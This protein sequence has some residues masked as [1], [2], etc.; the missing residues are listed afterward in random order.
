MKT[1]LAIALGG[2]ILVAAPGGRPFTVDDEMA[3]RSLVDVAI[4]PDGS[5]VAYVVSTPALA[6]DEHDAALFVVDV[7]EREAF[8][9]A[10]VATPVRL[11]EKLHIFNTPVPRPQLR[12]SPDSKTIALAATASN[13]PQVFAVDGRPGPSGPG[14][15]RQ[16]TNAPEG[17]FGF[18]WSPDGKSLAYLTRD[19]MSADEE[20][21][22]QDKSFVIR[23]DAPD[24]PARLTVQSL[25]AG[26]RP[27]TLT[28]P[29][30]YIDGFSW[31]PGGRELAYSAAPRS[32]FSAP[33]ED[34]LYRVS[35]DGGPPRTIVDRPGMNSFPKFSPDG[36]LLA[37]I[38]TTGHTDIMASRSLTVVAS[39]GGTPRA[40]VLDDAWANEYVWAPDSKSIYF[41]ANDGTFGRGAH[42]FEQ[43]VVRISVADG[44]AESVTAGAPGNVVA[45]DL[46][47]SRDGR[48][49]A[50]KGIEGRTMGDVYVLDT[51]NRAAK[52]LTDINPELRDI[53]LGDLK[54]VSWKS[55]DGMEIWGLLL[56]PPRWTPGQ[57][58]PLITYIHGGP[59]GGVT[60]G[61]FPQ[62][63]HSISQVDPYPTEALAS[64]G[65]AVLFPM[66]RGGAGYGEAG[67]R[68]IVNSWG[69]ADYKD[70]MAGVDRLIAQGVADEN[71]LGVMGAS[72]GGYMTNW[73]VT[74]TN[75]FKAASA[76]ASLTD[77]TDEYYMSEG[78]EFMVAYF[79]RPWENPDGYAQHSPLTFA[80][81]VTTPLLIQHGERDARVPIA[82][83]WKFYRAL[84]AMGKTVEFDIYP[85]GG[86][87]LYEPMLQREQM[88][89]NY[90]WFT[91]WIQP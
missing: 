9:R 15:A 40:F 14:D 24:R 28:P 68:M 89:R 22:R 12:W 47:I 18:E 82:G 6:R 86:H 78:G 34:H 46:S 69:E 52:K 33:Y 84:K 56:T 81:R 36:K 72:Y 8:S 45:F 64:A 70:I 74:Q 10:G 88:R 2:S 85:R 13:L 42:M 62:F 66:P 71:R 25:D 5:R 35:V 30:H 41:E 17:V 4:A 3:M 38:S 54:A 57:R 76:G 19:P 27:R 83:A 67:Q 32:G 55:F 44:R 77:L 26:A 29:A 59:G 37:F 61:L 80:N 60:Y 91:R 20:R 75:R 51:S 73:I 87:V 90:E 50:Y 63:M 23:A 21:G 16:L 65:Y 43:P 49:V 31:S 79:R 53:A 58:V 39:D 7:P 11:A 1:A 48:R